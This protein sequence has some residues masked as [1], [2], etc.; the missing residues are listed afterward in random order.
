MIIT[1]HSVFPLLSLSLSQFHQGMRSDLGVFGAVVLSLPERSVFG[2][3]RADV[4]EPSGARSCVMRPSRTSGV[5]PH[6]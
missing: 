1:F 6:R 3:D 2:G 4:R 5:Q